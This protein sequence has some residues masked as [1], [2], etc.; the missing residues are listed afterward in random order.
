METK[1]SVWKANLNNGVILGL[2][3]VVLSLILYFFDLITNSS[4]SYLILLIEAVVLYFMIKSY[5]DTVLNGYMT[6]GQSVGA[7]VVIFLYATI[8]STIFSYIL[9][10]FIDPGLINKMLTI[11]EE[12]LAKRGMAADAIDSAMSITKKM[13]KPEIMIISGLFG[14]V[15]GGTIISLII[16]IFTK[17]EGNPLTIDEPEKL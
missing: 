2:I 13:M 4:L 14:G 5:R 12:N 8:I 16:S 9:Y 1:A 15:F 3:G 10:K 7:G 11:A 6:Y 17:K